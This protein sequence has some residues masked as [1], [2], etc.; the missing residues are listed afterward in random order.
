MVTGFQ[1]FESLNLVSSD[2]Y[3]FILPYYDFDKQLFSD[4]NNGTINFRSSGSNDLNNTNNLRTKIINDLNFQ[5]SNIIFN[6]GFKNEYNLYLK[7]LNTVAKN[8]NL[9]KSSPQM[10]LMSIIEFNTSLPLINQINDEVN[11]LTPK[12]SF[13]LNPVDMKDYS[14][15]IDL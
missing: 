1:S 6:N 10:E 2:R 15:S 11:Y 7:N 8:D 13:R 4:Y 14:S 9:Y 3:Q 12:I 5:S